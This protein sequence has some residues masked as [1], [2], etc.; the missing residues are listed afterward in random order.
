MG[1][2]LSTFNAVTA[3][4]AAEH[5]KSVRRRFKVAILAVLAIVR[6]QQALPPPLYVHAGT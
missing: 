2:T 6:M 5:C 1:L 3:S 4:I